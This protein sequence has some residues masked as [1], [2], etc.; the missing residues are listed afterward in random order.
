M[1]FELLIE[2]IINWAKVGSNGSI[3]EFLGC[4]L[5]YNQ[6]EFPY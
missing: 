3:K 1:A 5:L 2:F 6:F 4:T